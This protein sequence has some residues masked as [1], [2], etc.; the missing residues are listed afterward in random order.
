VF[1]A[2]VVGDAFPQHAEHGEVAVLRVDAR[3]TEFEDFA[4]HR[5]ERAK[6]KNLRAVITE[7]RRGARAG[8]HAISADDIAGARVLDEEVVADFIERVGVKER[9]VGAFESFVEFHVED[10]EPQRLRVAH[11][12]GRRGEAQAVGI[13]RAAS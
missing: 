13:F 11:V 9:G 2:G 12:G 10:E 3:A 1:F 7:T 5:F 4:A 6:V 8:L